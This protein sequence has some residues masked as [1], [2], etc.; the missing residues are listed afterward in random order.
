MSSS[1]SIPRSGTRGYPGNLGLLFAEHA[2]PRR[3]PRSSIC[4]TPARPRAGELPRARR[5]AATRSRAAC[6]RA[7]LTPGDRI[8]HPLAQPRT[9]SSRRCSARCARA[10][11]RSRSTSSSPPTRSHTSSS[12]AGAKLRLRRARARGACARR[13]C[14]VDRSF[15]GASFERFLDPGDVR[16]VRARARFGRD[17]A[18]HLGLDRPA[19]RRA[20]HALRP[21]LEPAH[22]RAHA[23]HDASTT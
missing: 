4:A 10:S 6:A 12:D 7:G 16:R 15:G 18:L 13:A 23:R 8:A 20:A 22:P 2:Q 17:P 19:E 9:S 1:A 14:D 11:C 3:A 5:A 21:E